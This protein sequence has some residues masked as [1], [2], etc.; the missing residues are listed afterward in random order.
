MA[1]IKMLVENDCGGYNPIRTLTTQHSQTRRHLDEGFLTREKPGHKTL[2]ENGLVQEFLSETNQAISRKPQ[3]FHMKSLI[4]EMRYSLVGITGEVPAVADVSTVWDAWATEYVH[5]GQEMTGWHRQF[6]QWNSL[7]EPDKLHQSSKRD[8]GYQD[9]ALMW[10]EEYLTDIPFIESNVTTLDDAPMCFI[11]SNVRWT[12]SVSDTCPLAYIDTG[13]SEDVSQLNNLDLNLCVD[14]ASGASGA[15]GADKQD[16]LS[17]LEEN[18]K[19]DPN[20]FE[21][22]KNNFKAGDLPGAQLLL[23]CAV[24]QFPFNAEA[25]Q[26]LEFMWWANWELEYASQTNKLWS[27]TL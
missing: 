13:W 5:T 26:L 8:G 4:Q 21:A 12:E 14:T 16:C 2:T 25:W 23:E 17:N 27:K 7:D 24:K 22:G 10:A 9:V 1:L 20:A 19:N 11:S 18:W 15:S 3:T 6:L